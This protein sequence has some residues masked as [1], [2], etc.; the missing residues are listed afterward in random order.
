LNVNVALTPALAGHASISRMNASASKPT[1]TRH[2]NWASTWSCMDSVA[3]VMNRR[4]LGV[5]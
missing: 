2:A 5:S 3:E 1:G 4:R